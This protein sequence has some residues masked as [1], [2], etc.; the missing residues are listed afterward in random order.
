MKLAGLPLMKLDWHA[1]APTIHPGQQ[2]TATWRSA[3]AGDIRLRLVEYS[4]GY[5]GDHWCVKGHLLQVLE[6]RL[7]LELDGRAPVDVSAGEGLAIADDDVPHR[8]VSPSGAK[9]FLVD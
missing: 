5:V 7:T 8:P 4:A 6:G 1:I 3:Q 9:L 2:G